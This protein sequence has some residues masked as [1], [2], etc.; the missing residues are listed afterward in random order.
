MD[1]SFA[2]AST[3]TQSLRERLQI[4]VAELRPQEVRPKRKQ[5]SCAH[6]RSFVIAHIILNIRVSTGLRSQ[7]ASMMQTATSK[8]CMQQY[9]S[10]RVFPWARRIVRS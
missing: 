7:S 1:L 4:C 9:R 3:N 5:T 2:D 6:R 10:I 8:R